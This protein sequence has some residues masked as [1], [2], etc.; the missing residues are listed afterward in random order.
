M[1]SLSGKLGQEK[2]LAAKLGFLKSFTLC[3]VGKAMSAHGV[4]FLRE[5]L[6]KTSILV[7]ADMLDT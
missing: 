6:V 2:H 1:V 7:C 5:I 3:Q 4:R